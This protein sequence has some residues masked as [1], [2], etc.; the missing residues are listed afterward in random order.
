[1]LSWAKKKG[2]GFGTFKGESSQEDGK[3]KCLVNKCWLCHA[4][5]MELREECDL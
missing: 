3:N 5:T 2:G 4:E 1:M